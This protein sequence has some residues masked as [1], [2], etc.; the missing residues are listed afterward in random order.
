MELDHLISF[1]QIALSLDERRPVFY[2]LD[3]SDDDVKALDIREGSGRTPRP[4]AKV[5][6]LTHLIRI[7]LSVS[8]HVLNY[9]IWA[10]KTV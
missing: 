8:N 6:A 7:R 1:S 3:E 5:R 2:D 10:T 4:G 9:V